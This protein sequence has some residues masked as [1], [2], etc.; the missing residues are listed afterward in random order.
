MLLQSFQVHS[1]S[2]LS[3]CSNC[4]RMRRPVQPSRLD[5]WQA[6]RRCCFH[7]VGNTAGVGR[8]AHGLREI[9]QVDVASCRVHAH[10]Q[11]SA[12][13]DQAT[14]LGLQCQ[15]QQ[16]KRLNPAPMLGCCLV[17]W[18]EGFMSP[19]ANTKSVCRTYIS[20][21]MA[22]VADITPFLL[23]NQISS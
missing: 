10:Q 20:C 15:N 22:N 16:P 3:R 13:L 23:Q 6:R 17:G 5:F 19:S 7:G 2:L 1:T 4:A 18:G 12:A 14:P 9:G 11:G 8:A 21:R